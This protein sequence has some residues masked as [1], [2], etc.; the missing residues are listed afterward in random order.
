MKQ[1]FIF[2]VTVVLL[3]AILN[4]ASAELVDRKH[5]FIIG[6][7]VGLHTP[8]NGDL[9]GI[10]GNGFHY[11]FK[12]GFG[13]ASHFSLMGEFAESRY[14]MV[15]AYKGLNKRTYL[16]R[17]LACGARYNFVAGAY[18]IPYAEGLFGVTYFRSAEPGGSDIYPLKNDILPI[19]IATFGSEF[20]MGPNWCMEGSIDLYRIFG[21]VNL[22]VLFKNDPERTVNMPS[23]QPLGFHFRI[24]FLIF[25]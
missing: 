9:D 4:P 3:T 14:G 21:D 22:Q 18:I 13:I 1:R 2:V 23:F 12:S 25:L 19:G 17:Y 5:L 16:H 15:E 11:Y 20:F 8:I 7:G 24:G 6:S 10:Y